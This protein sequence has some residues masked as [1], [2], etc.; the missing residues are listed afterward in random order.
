M[1][2]LLQLKNLLY[3]YL[4]YTS[5]IAASYNDHLNIVTELLKNNADVNA[6]TNEGKSIYIFLCKIILICYLIFKHSILLLKY[7]KF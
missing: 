3:L 1:N 4:G 5:L 6:E 7:S 2:L